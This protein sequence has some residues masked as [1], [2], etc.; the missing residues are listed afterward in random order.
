MRGF[1]NLLYESIGGVLGIGAMIFFGGGAM[2]LGMPVFALVWAVLAWQRRQPYFC[3]RSSSQKSA[4]SVNPS[5]LV[6]RAQGTVSSRGA[7]CRRRT[8]SRITTFGD[9]ALL[10][11]LGG[12]VHAGYYSAANKLILAL[13]MIPAA[14]S[15]G[16]FPCTELLI[17]TW[18][19]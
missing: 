8:F 16:L 9:M 6:A 2:L 7:L 17:C 19:G 3:A 14:V 12:E 13:N 1:Q 18:R 11:K 10:P 4:P 15:S 5:H